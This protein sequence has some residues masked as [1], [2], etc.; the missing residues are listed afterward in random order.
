MAGSF[1]D[2]ILSLFSKNTDPEAEK[3]KLLKEILRDISSN[4]YNKFYRIK[5][6]EVDS[7]LGKFFYDIYKLIAPAQYAM[8]NALH[9]DLLKQITVEAFLDKTFLDIQQRITMDGISVQAK[10]KSQKEL[11]SGVKTDLIMF[12]S[13]FDIERIN[14][15]NRCYNLI[16]AFDQFVNFGFY[17][18]VKKFDGAIVER[19]FTYKPRFANLRGERLS[20]DIKDFL[21][22]SYRLDPAFDWKTVFKVLKTYKDDV[23]VINPDMWV[24]ILTRLQDIHKSG[25]LFLMVRYIDQN[26]VWQFKPATNNEHIA[27]L[28]LESINTEVQENINKIIRSQKDSQVGEL[29]RSIFGVDNI[30]CLSNYTD[31]ANEA[32]V[33][34]NIEGFSHTT[35]LNYLKAFITNCYR[36]DMKEVFDLILV[37]GRWTV[38]A[39]FHEVSDAAHAI[40]ALVEQ[41]DAFDASI[42]DRSDRGSRLFTA[43]NRIDRDKSQA[44]YIKILMKDINEGAEKLSTNAL[45]VLIVIGKHLHSVIEDS[46]KNPHKLVINWK[47]LE[48]AAGEPILPQLQLAYKK[49]YTFI[50]MMQLLTKNDD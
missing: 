37:R 49:L 46:Q 25:I 9:S 20:D 44:K 7:S 40:E 22:V 10:T 39:L 1:L 13:A 12:K 8:V 29:A 5:S 18:L 28:Y 41:I 11:A 3:K 2:K 16:L 31:K 15:I 48:I 43:F 17:D 6:E 34:K 33:T 30:V 50:Q 38:N 4:K 35:E 26:P 45:S 42:S 19:S 36:Q 32:Y 24:K 23:D 27:E 47:E 21:E 14:N